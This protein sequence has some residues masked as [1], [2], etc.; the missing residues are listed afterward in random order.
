LLKLYKPSK[1]S[2]LDADDKGLIAQYLGFFTTKFQKVSIN[3]VIGVKRYT[4]AAEY[5]YGA[6][7]Y[8]DKGRYITN[9]VYR[10]EDATTRD[11]WVAK[12]RTDFYTDSGYR[13]RLPARTARTLGFVD[14]VA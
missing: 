2:S 14:Y 9:I 3:G 7:M 6:T 12:R 4:Y 8:D 13:G 11:E 1:V 10:F 5:T